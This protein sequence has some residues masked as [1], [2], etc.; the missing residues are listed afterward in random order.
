[1]F[2]LETIMRFGVKCN[3]HTYAYIPLIRI[4]QKK[5]EKLLFLTSPC[6]HNKCT[7]FFNM[8]K[9]PQNR[10]VCIYIYIYKNIHVYESGYT[11]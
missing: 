8:E 6:H 5:N 4:P 1:M 9:T 7:Q 11:K 2:V 10:R 3:V